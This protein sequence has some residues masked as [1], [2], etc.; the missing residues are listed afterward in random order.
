MRP[1]VG[2]YGWGFT[3]LMAAYEKALREGQVFVR[4]TP[5]HD[6][7]IVVMGVDVGSPDGDKTAHACRGVN[8]IDF[9]I[10]DDPY[11]E[12]HTYEGEFHVVPP[13]EAMSTYV[14]EIDE[15]KLIVPA[16]NEVKNKG[17]QPRTKYPRR[18]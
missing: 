13:R 9:V 7:S 5:M 18:R 10:I 8:G 4:S 16:R 12:A 15:A 17:P 2:F 14:R 6:D 11:Q 3:Q 1:R